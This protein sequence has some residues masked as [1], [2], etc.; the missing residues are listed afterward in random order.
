MEYTQWNIKNVIEGREWKTL[1]LE[2]SQAYLYLYIYIINI[3]LHC[4]QNNILKEVIS[5]TR[6]KI[7]HFNIGKYS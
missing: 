5:S 7:S 4:S 2:I 6:V 3:Y 1:I